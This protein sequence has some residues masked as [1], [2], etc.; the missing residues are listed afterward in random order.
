MR[1][2][3]RLSPYPILNDYGDDYIESS[4]SAEFEASAQFSEICGHLT[5]SLC[6]D[7]IQ[8]LIDNEEAE[9]VAHIECP[10]TCF[11]LALSSFENEIDFKIDATKVTKLIEIRTFIILKKDVKDF[12]SPHFHPDYNGQKFDLYKHQI[13]A[14][15]TAIDYDVIKDENDLE[16]LPSIVRITRL[17]DKSKGS[18]SVNTEDDAHILIGLSEEVFEIYA[19]LGKNAFKS[20]AFSLIILPAMVIVLQRM[21]LNREDESYTSMHWYKVIENILERNGKSVNDINIETDSLLT[22]CQSIF[23]DPIERSFKEL[24]TCSER[25][26]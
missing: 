8:E 11:R 22:L 14:V 12:T 24:R 6:N 10:A 20:T 7:D 3:N 1:I 17:S 19:R 16:S 2:K 13:I 23:G 9:F 15:G 21:Y 26:R 5:F 25:M 18:L 4:F